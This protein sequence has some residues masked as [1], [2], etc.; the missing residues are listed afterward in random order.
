MA[1][2]TTGQGKREIFLEKGPTFDLFDK[3]NMTSHRYLLLTYMQVFL[4][5]LSPHSI[6]LLAGVL[7]DSSPLGLHLYF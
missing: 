1:T 5:W 3:D 6:R 4:F 7:Y 2:I